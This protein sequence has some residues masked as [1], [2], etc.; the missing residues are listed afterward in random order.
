MTSPSLHMVSILYNN[1]GA[2]QNATLQVNFLFLKITVKKH[3]FC[4][5]ENLANP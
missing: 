4:T 2:M 1:G 3:L 5:Q